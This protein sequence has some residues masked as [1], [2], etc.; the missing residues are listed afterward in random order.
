[1]ATF[2]YTQIVDG[3]L[4][5]KSDVEY[6]FDAWLRERYPAVSFNIA[7]VQV[8]KAAWME[9]IE[10]RTNLEGPEIGLSPMQSHGVCQTEVASLGAPC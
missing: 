6:K 7:E 8:I 2:T 3:I 4:S 10:W 9:A 1:M 5:A